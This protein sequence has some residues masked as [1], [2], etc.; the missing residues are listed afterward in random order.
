LHP[1]FIALIQEPIKMAEPDVRTPLEH[2]DIVPYKDKAGKGRMTKTIL[3][4]TW[5]SR[6]STSVSV[7]VFQL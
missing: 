5:D 4:K 1:A 7:S 6:R 3:V 2:H